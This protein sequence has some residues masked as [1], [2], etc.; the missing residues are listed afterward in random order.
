MS[1]LNPLPTILQYIIAVACF[2][3]TFMMIM[4]I[5][6]LCST[7]PSNDEDSTYMNFINSVQSSFYPDSSSS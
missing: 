7:P 6:A 4:I 2:F 1:K 3:V 5:I